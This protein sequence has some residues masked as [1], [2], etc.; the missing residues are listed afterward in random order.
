MLRQAVE[1]WIH[2]YNNVS[3]DKLTKAV[4]K[5]VIYVAN[6]FLLGKAVLLPWA[7][8]VFLQAYEIQ[9]IGSIKSARVILETGESSVIFSSRWLLH[10]LITYLNSYMLY[11][12]VHMKF[13]TILYHK[14]ADI[15]VSLSWALGAIPFSGDRD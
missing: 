11:K 9:H 15:L 3:T 10:Q 5:T 1:E 13:G 14:G 2:K 7:C 6:Q 4:L 8:Q 12:C